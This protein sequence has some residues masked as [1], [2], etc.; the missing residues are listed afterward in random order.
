MKSD[1]RRA[2]RHVP[3]YLRPH[4]VIAAAIGHRAAK[5]PPRQVIKL[6]PSQAMKQR[7]K[8]VPDVKKYITETTMIA[9]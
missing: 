8:I 9:A 3:R 6:P 2:R 1:F 5:P 7:I 4:V